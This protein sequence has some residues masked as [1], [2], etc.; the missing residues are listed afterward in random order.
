MLSFIY[1]YIYIY[2]YITTLLHDELISYIYYIYIPSLSYMIIF[3][4]SILF[5]YITHT[6]THI[7]HLYVNK[8]SYITQHSYFYIIIIYNETYHVNKC[9][10]NLI[11]CISSIN[12]MSLF[13]ASIIDMIIPAIYIIP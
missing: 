5:I 8:S 13:Y 9:V 12:N 4:I 2:I 6:H 3:N 10:I 11:N 7:Y 1:I